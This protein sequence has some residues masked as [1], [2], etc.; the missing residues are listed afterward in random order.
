MR[1]AHWIPK[2]T[3]SNNSCTNA[4]QSYVYALGLSRLIHLQTLFHIHDMPD[5]SLTAQS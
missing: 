4:P 3:D 1:V 2:T 5:C